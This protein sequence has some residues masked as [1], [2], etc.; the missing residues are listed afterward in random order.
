LPRCR[1]FGGLGTGHDTDA[2]RRRSQPRRGH[3]HSAGT[4]RATGSDRSGPHAPIPRHTR[5]SNI[6]AQA[7]VRW[8][9]GD[10]SVVVAALGSPRRSAERQPR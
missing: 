3:W 9:E 10:R 5:H 6:R 4:A 8:R 7:E 2:T 1:V